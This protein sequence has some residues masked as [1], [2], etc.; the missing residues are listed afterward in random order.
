[1]NGKFLIKPLRKACVFNRKSLLHV[2][3]QNMWEEILVWK[4]E[5]TYQNLCFVETGTVFAPGETDILHLFCQKIQLHAVEV[6]IVIFRDLS[7]PSCMSYFRTGNDGM[8]P[9]IRDHMIHKLV[10]PSLL[11]SVHTGILRGHGEPVYCACPFPCFLPSSKGVDSG[12]HYP[13]NSA[14]LINHDDFLV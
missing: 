12:K 14:E 7:A 13:K 5:E 11:A 10:A 6:G 2:P 8:W 9:V 3:R 4:Y 1:M